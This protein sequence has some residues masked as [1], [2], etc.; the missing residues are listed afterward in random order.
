MNTSDLEK[1]LSGKEKVTPVWQL[2][3]EVEP[4]I[5]VGETI[6]SAQKY[7]DYSNKM[8]DAK[9]LTFEVLYDDTVVG[10]TN[11]ADNMPRQLTVNLEDTQEHIEHSLA[12]RLSGKIDSHSCTDRDDD[13]S[14]ILKF[15]FWIEQLPMTVQFSKSGSFVLGQNESQ[16]MTLATPIYSWLLNNY[17]AIIQDYQLAAAGQDLTV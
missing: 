10:T 14:W 5:T 12:F 11:F 16:S 17:D 3:V 9:K 15:K 8:L 6:Y 13:V 2:T 7:L 4:M 1:L